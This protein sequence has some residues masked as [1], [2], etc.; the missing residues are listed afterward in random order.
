MDDENKK[1]SD[2]I[3][4]VE[5]VKMWRDAVVMGCSTIIIC[6]IIGVV[7]DAIKKRLG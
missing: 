2:D 7:G 4:E 5:S 3:V 6:K 1:D